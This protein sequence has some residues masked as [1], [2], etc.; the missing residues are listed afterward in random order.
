MVTAQLGKSAETMDYFKWG[1]CI[2][3]KLYL[4]KTPKN[5]LAEN[6]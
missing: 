6:L 4:S 3:G 1:N 5:R 2:L